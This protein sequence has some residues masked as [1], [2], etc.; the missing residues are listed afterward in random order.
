MEMLADKHLEEFRADACEAV[1][2]RLSKNIIPFPYF[3]L[4]RH[5]QDFDDGEDFHPDFTHQIFGER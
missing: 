3:A 5:K 1:H 2:F 4:V